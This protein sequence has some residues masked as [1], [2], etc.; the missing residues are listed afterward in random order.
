MQYRI[1][2]IFMQRVYKYI[3]SSTVYNLLSV[4]YLSIS[5]FYGQ[6]LYFLRHYIYQSALT[7]SYF[8]NESLE[9]KADI[10]LFNMLHIWNI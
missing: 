6:I 8:A 1:S 9:Y 2:L 5:S 10:S 3:Y 7:T 4:L